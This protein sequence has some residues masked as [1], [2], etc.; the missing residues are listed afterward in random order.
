MLKLLMRIRRRKRALRWL[1]NKPLR[2]LVEFDP[3][4]VYDEYGVTLY[5]TNYS[6]E[7]GMT[8][9]GVG[10]A[11]GNGDDFNTA[12]DDLIQFCNGKTL[13]FGET[14]LQFPYV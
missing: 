3:V 12:F 9:D 4:G 1:A 8:E 6:N 2:V 5:L 10:R 7:I 11:F 14:V 13:K